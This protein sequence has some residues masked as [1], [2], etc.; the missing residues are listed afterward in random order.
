MLDKSLNFQTLVKKVA[1]K[2]GTTEKALNF[3]KKN[4]HFSLLISQAIS[5]AE[6]RSKEI[7]KDLS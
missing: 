3:L 7:A 2:N 5:R 6:K 1:S 4:N